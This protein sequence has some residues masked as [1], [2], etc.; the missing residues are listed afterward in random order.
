[1]HYLRLPWEVIE[2]T[3]PAERPFSITPWDSD[4]DADGHNLSDLRK[5]NFDAA[6]ELTISSGAITITQTLHTVDTEGDASTDDLDTINGGTAGDVLYLRAADGSRT[7]VLKHGTGNIVTSDG[8]DYSLDDANKEVQLRYGSDSKWHLVGSAGG[9]LTAVVDDTSPQ[10]GGD[11]DAQ[12][13]AI[14]EVSSL[15]TSEVKARDA[16]GLKL[17]DD[18][19]NGIFVEDGGNVGIGTDS[20]NPSESGV[21]KAVIIQD[22]AKPWLE[23]CSSGDTSDTTS[24]YPG[25]GIARYMGGGSGHPFAFF[26]LAGGSTDSPS[27]VSANQTVGLFVF[28]AHNGTEFRDVAR[29]GAKTDSGFTSGDQE[30][31]LVFYT[32]D[33]TSY[34]ERMRIDHLGHV[35]IG[36][37]G[38]GYMLDVSGDIHCTGKLTSDGGNDP[39]YVLYNYESRASIIE[40]VKKEV[41]PDKLNGAVLFFNGDQGQ[42][43][44]FLPSKGEFRT[45]DGKVLETVKPITKTFET[46]DR[47]YF[48]EDTGEIKT[49]KAK[50]TVRRY[51]LKPDHEIDPRTGKIKR[52]IRERDPKTGEEIEIGEEEVSLDEAIERVEKKAKQSKRSKKKKL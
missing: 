21:T 39:P 8:N 46:E 36:T 47:Y 25:F 18:A 14:G 35:G 51:Q 4:I 41:L 16:N 23:I 12:D 44:L 17:Y 38:P 11:L 27:S 5:L 24:Y 9:G 34:S 19:G 20:P 45:L 52:K 49:Y 15:A 22:V 6:T 32:G 26:H 13:H 3:R 37:N 40:R 48:D 42:L 31:V 7:V 2:I 1:M 33:G 30:G 50:K 29:F 43:E 28:R 10:L